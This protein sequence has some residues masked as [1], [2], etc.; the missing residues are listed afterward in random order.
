MLSL[1]TD[2]MIRQAAMHP[3]VWFHDVTGSVNLQKRDLFIM[4]A[5][6]PT[7]KTFPANLTNIPS[8]QRW[9][10]SCLFVDAYVE[11]YGVITC[12][13]NMCSLFDQ[14]P[15]EYGAFE[16]AIKSTGLFPNSKVL[17]CVFHAV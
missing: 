3:E 13:R 8:G 5:R 15:A 2:D 10:F 6:N 9:V 7:G 17:L 14:D 16:N 1:A 11:I 4:A 12:S